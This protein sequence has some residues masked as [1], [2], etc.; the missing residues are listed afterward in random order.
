MLLYPFK[1][2]LKLLLNEFTQLFWSLQLYSIQREILVDMKDYLHDDILLSK[3]NML[4]FQL[5][6]PPPTQTLREYFKWVKNEICLFFMI[7]F[8][9]NE[10]GSIHFSS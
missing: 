2:S 4:I 5:F 6:P 9:S 8:F 3:V 7:M 1:S 10:H